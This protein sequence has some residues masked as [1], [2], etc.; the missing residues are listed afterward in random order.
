MKGLPRLLLITLMAISTIPVQAGEWIDVPGPK[1][2]GKD[3]TLPGL[4]MKPEGEGPFP[5]VVIAHGC[6]GMQQQSDVRW[7]RRF[8]EWGYAALMIDS[9]RPRGHLESCNLNV[10]QGDR[11]RDAHA[12]KKWLTTQP[13]AKPDR[14]ALFGISHGGFGGLTAVNRANYPH[15]TPFQA[16]VALYPWCAG[17]INVLGSPLLVLIGDA[18]EVTP[19][20]R[21]EAMKIRHL[22][23]H[24]YALRVITGATHYFDIEELVSLKLRWPNRDTTPGSPDYV[25]MEMKHDPEAARQAIQETKTFLAQHL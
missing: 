6:Q 13:F 18:D 25:V 4:L 1:Y 22:E 23:G 11:A 3:L 7:A 12:A 20:A 10:T 9:F 2:R 24:D 15:D 5:V 16:V 21:C 17:N 14:I 8:N 19:K